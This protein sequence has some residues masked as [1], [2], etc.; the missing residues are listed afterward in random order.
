MN[1]N[2]TIKQSNL[3]DY[4]NNSISFYNDFTYR[5][6]LYKKVYETLPDAENIKFIKIHNINQ[7]NYIKSQIIILTNLIK[8]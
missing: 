6:E 7:P 3:G 8:L 4:K 1:K 2:I 5:I